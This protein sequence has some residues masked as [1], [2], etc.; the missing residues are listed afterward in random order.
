MDNCKVAVLQHQRGLPPIFNP[1]Y[2]D[3]ARH[4][5][6]QPRACNPL[7]PNENGRVERA[8]GYVKR[9]FLAG[10]DLGIW[11]ASNWA[12]SSNTT[13][14]WPSKRPGNSGHTVTI[15][16]D[17]WRGRCSNVESGRLNLI[18]TSKSET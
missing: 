3:F 8:V 17:W 13:A 12:I 18:L 9:N 15:L 14:I 10:R 4:H 7:S 11:I 16:P 1:R 6:C 2:L 5:G